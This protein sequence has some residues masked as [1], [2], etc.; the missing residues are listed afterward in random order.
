MFPQGPNTGGKTASLKTLGVLVLMAKAGMFLP[1][2]G[3]DYEAPHLPWFDKVLVDIGDSQSLQQSLSTFSGHVKR[4]KA[5]CQHP[6]L[7]LKAIETGWTLPLLICPPVVAQNNCLSCNMR[8]PE[9]LHL[10]QKFKS[11][12]TECKKDDISVCHS[13][14]Y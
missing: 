3:N 4:L 12:V 11:N 10:Q 13:H 1:V 2:G 8:I 5:V 6:S 7:L 9:L 14:R